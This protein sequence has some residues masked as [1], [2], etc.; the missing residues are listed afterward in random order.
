MYVFGTGRTR[1]V[2]PKLKSPVKNWRN[3]FQRILAFLGRKFEKN[4]EMI[5]PS[6]LRCYPSRKRYPS[7]LIRIKRELK[8]YIL[9]DQ[10]C[11]RIRYLQAFLIV[12][13]LNI[14]LNLML[15]I[16][17]HKPEMAIALTPFEMMCGFRRMEDIVNFLQC[18]K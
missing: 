18:N 3:L 6:C 16:Q 1:V 5:F 13:S 8:C 2:Q 15:C 9:L 11:I 17:N 14:I 7:R 12:Y 4:L 10:I